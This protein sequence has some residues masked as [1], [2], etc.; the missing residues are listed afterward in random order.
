[1]KIQLLFH[2]FVIF[3]ILL[4]AALP[5]IGV[6]I[7]GEIAA[8]NGCQLDEGSAHP[9]IVN[10]RDIGGTLYSLG[11][12]GWLMIATIPLGLGLAAVYILFVAG[13][14]IIRRAMRARAA[15]GSN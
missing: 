1:M 6:A 12:L 4:I 9:C 5:L 7:A 3:Q 14:Y 8:A 13:F 15:A 2:G 11:V 10:G